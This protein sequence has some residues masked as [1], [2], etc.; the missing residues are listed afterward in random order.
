MPST[1]VLLSFLACHPH[2]SPTR[3]NSVVTGGDGVDSCQIRKETLE[4]GAGVT[5]QAVPARA[6]G[7]ALLNTLLLKV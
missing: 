1:C 2:Y 4:Q 7:A 5:A 3:G 6:D